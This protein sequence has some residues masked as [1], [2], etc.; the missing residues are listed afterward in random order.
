MSICQ[1][2]AGIELGNFEFLNENLS[3]LIY[4][5]T[6]NKFL[7]FSLSFLKKFL[8]RKFEKL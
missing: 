8:K 5:I 4:F 3:D 7:Y 1:K 2:P 6:F